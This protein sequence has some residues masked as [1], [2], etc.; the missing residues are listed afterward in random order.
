MATTGTPSHSAAGNGGRPVASSASH[1][2]HPGQRRLRTKQSLPGFNSN[3]L[4]LL[5][6][7]VTGHRIAV[8]PA[9]YRKQYGAPFSAGARR[10]KRENGSRGK[11][12]SVS[13]CV[14]GWV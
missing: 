2:I 10:R 12:G 4:F 14:R 3:C 6:K 8:I 7:S 9:A 11:I 1:T 13:V 5:E